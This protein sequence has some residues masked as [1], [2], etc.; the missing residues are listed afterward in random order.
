MNETRGWNTTDVP[1]LHGRTAVVTGANTGIGWQT[2][3]ALAEH[4]ATVVLACRDMAKAADAAGRITADVPTAEVSLLELDLASQA[5]VRRAAE[6]VRADHPRLDLLI[7]NAGAVVR[8]HTLTDDGYEKTLATNHLGHFA[9]TGLV[10]DRLMAVPGSRVVTVSSVGHK[11]GTI[12]FDDL[13]QR[14]GYQAAYFQAKLANLLYAYELQRRLA[15]AGAATVAVA[16]HPGNARTEFGRDMSL[17]VRVMMSPHLRLLTSW[18]MQDPPTAALPVI[19]AAADPEVR[20]GDYY[21]PDGRNEFTGHPVRVRSS[22]SSYDTAA[23]RRLWQESERM[24]G[25]TYPLGARTA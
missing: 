10:L 24:T 19:R 16:A 21:G 18:L 23:Q 4:G 22:A 11:R 6:Q 2:A 13:H 8:Q 3:K 1:D 20:G 12:H 14:R 9:F 17:F 5:S 7:N 15:A 25:V